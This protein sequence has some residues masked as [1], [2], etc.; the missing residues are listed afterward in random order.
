MC[1]GRL[2][3][4][5]ICSEIGMNV[6]PCGEK[7]KDACVV[8]LFSLS[9]CIKTYVFSISYNQ[10][11]MDKA[12]ILYGPMDLKAI[13]DKFK[14]LIDEVTQNAYTIMNPDTTV[15]MLTDRDGNQIVAPN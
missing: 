8:T 3:A 14:T 13:N 12:E 9:K 15:V 4:C 7:V 1:R 5:I 2:S 6:I 11:C 10:S